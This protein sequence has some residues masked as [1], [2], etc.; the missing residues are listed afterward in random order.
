[1]LTQFILT[2]P[3]VKFESRTKYYLSFEFATGGELLDR[4]LAKGK[5]TEHDVVIVIRSILDAVHYLHRHGIIHR[6]LKYA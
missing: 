5:F 2:Q 6:D 3:Q 1:L 4:I